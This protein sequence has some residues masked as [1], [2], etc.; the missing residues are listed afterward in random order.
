[1]AGYSDESIEVRDS[2]AD[3]VTMETVFL[4]FWSNR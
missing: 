2:K 4:V 1:M 3:A